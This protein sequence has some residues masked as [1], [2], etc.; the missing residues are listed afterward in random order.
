MLLKE[1][2]QII[3]GQERLGIVETVDSSQ[4]TE[5]RKVSINSQEHFLREDY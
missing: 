2:D 1:Y 3:R 5:V 4:P